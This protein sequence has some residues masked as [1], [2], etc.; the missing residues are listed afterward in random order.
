VHIVKKVGGATTH[1]LTEICNTK[2]TK[3]DRYSLAN[4]S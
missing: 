3:H 4:I 1:A 2:Q